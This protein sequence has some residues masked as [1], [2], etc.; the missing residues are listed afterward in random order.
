M[1]FGTF[2]VEQVRLGLQLGNPNLLALVVVE[3]GGAVTRRVP[4][5]RSQRG[6]PIT[7]RWKPLTGGSSIG[8]IGRTA[9]RALASPGVRPDRHRQ[10]RSWGHEGAR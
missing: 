9:S 5:P 6:P 2:A 7:L 1:R 10:G 4:M 3:Y 8:N